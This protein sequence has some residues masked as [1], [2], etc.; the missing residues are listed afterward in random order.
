MKE[1]ALKKNLPNIGST[2]NRSYIP[3]P[4]PA[5][6]AFFGLTPNTPTPQHPKAWEPAPFRLRRL[7]IDKDHSDIIH[8]SSAWVNSTE[9]EKKRT[10]FPMDSIY[11]SYIYKRNPNSCSKKGMKEC[12]L[13]KIELVSCIINFYH[14]E[15]YHIP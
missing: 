13:L 12:L 4:K 11:I 8:H 2:K 3:P 5:K 15:K 7:E 1:T 14:L 10:D 6:A 9:K